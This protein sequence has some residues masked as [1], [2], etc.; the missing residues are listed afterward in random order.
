MNKEIKIEI[1]DGT[2]YWSDGTPLG[3]CERL[4]PRMC[5]FVGLFGAWAFKT[6]FS[7]VRCSMLAFFFYFFYFLKVKTESRSNFRPLSIFLII[8]F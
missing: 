5:R 3:D 8:K 4:H 1:N 7:G 2:I 6:A